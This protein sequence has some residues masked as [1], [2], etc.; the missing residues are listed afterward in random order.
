[1][2]NDYLQKDTNT[3]FSAKLILRKKYGKV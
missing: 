2:K 3:H 1:M